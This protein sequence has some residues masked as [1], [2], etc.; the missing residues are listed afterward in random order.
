MQLYLTIHRCVMPQRLF[1]AYLRNQ[2]CG[3]H[4]GSNVSAH[5]G[6]FVGS[7]LPGPLLPYNAALNGLAKPLH[8]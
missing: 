5:T 4:E 3:D 8:G 2:L 1:V 6:K 7:A